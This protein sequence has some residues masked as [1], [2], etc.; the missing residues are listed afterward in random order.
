MD[1]STIW[2]EDYIK[3]GTRRNTTFTDSGDGSNWTLDGFTMTDG[4]EVSEHSTAYIAENRGY[5]SFDDTLEVGPYNFGFLDVYGNKVEHF[6]YQDG[7]LISYW[8][9]S[10]TDNNVGEH[11][12]EGLILPIDAHPTPMTW[13]DESY[14]RTRIQV[15][16]AT[17]DVPGTTDSFTLHKNSVPT[18]VTGLAEVS[19]FDDTDQYWFAEKPDAGVKLPRTGTTITVTGKSGNTMDVSVTR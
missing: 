15:Y 7:L 5:R 17:F 12:G 19:T 10:Q 2:Q 6:P 4:N 11:P 13:S 3:V 18:D 14:M 1:N 8:D 16:D 9:S